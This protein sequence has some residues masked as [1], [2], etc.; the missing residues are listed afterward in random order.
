[1]TTYTEDFEDGELGP[2][3]QAASNTGVG[4]YARVWRDLCDFDPCGAN[5]SNQV[6]FIELY[7]DIWILP[8]PPAGCG[9]VNNTGG[10]L[11]GGFHLEN[12]VRSPAMT[13]PG[14]DVDGLTLAFDVYVHELLIANDSPGMFYVWDVRSTAG[15]DI[16]EAPW[17]GRDFVYYGG[18]VFRRSQNQVGDLLVPGATQVQVRL[19]VAELG[20]QFGY[21]EG[22]N[23]TSA[24]YFDNVRVQ[25]Y[26]SA[27]PRIVIT[28]QRLANDGFPASG[29]LDLA[30]LGANSVRFD[31]ASN[32]SL[33][34]HLRNDP[35]DFRRHHRLPAMARRWIHRP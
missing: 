24:P 31:M 7:P 15:G 13:L 33:R 22:T 30:D 5:T 1:V 18:P 25:A 8:P 12:Y 2:D 14:G 34:T 28:E 16:N 9:M 26:P 19:G 23:G 32:I 17:V 20:W 3:W 29:T 27:G 4:D 11:G 21:G 35:G 6:A 10:P